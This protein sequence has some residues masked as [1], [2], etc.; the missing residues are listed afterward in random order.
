MKFLSF[1]RKFSA[2][3]A[4]AAGL[5]ICSGCDERNTVPDRLTV[6]RGADQCSADGRFPDEVRVEAR[7]GKV[8]VSGVRLVFAAAPGSQ[9]EFSPA[10]GVTDG[11]GAVAVKV[12][13]HGAGDHFFTVCAPEYPGCAPLKLRVLS[14]M[15]LL[16]GVREAVAGGKLRTPVAVR[17]VR[18]G[19]GV[20]GVPVRFSMR[21]TAEGAETTA[22][23]SAPDA[24]TDASGTAST[25]VRLGRETGIYNLAVDVDG[26]AQGFLIRDYPVRLV[27][28]NPWRVG[29]AVLGGVALFIFGMMLMSDG[30]RTAAGERM[31][32]ILRF[33]TGNRVAALL[34]GTVVTA[35]L[36]SSAAVTV[37][38]IGFINAGLLTLQQ[39]LGI[40]FGA[41]IGTT[42]TAQIISFDLSG[43]ALPAVAAGVILSFSKRR[44]AKN[45]GKAVIGFG[46]L[47]YGLNLMSGELKL[48]GESSGFKAFFASFDCAPAHPGGIV[49]PLALLGAMFVGLAGTVILQSSSAFTGVTL[50]LAAGGLVNFYTAF[51]LLLGSNIGTTVTTLLAAAR[52]N[53]V[54][55]QAALAHFIFN[56]A[57]AVLMAAL[58][59]VPY[60]GRPV[61][62]GFIN[63]ITP[64]DAFAAIPQNLERH[65][66]MAHTFF[67]VA[68]AALLLPFA[69]QFA[70]L[71]GSILPV[72]DAAGGRIRILE[73]RLLSTPS[74]ALKQASAALRS[75][76][77]EA[78]VM[79]DRAV[80]R[81]FLPGDRGDDGAEIAEMEERVDAA[82]QEITDYLVQLSRRPLT[83]AQAELI[84]LLM[85]ATNDAERIADHA[86]NIIELTIRMQEGGD[87]LSERAVASLK[88]LWTTLDD[89]AR[90]VMN[91]LGSG[92]AD[93]TATALADEQRI[94]RETARLETE[95][96]ERLRKGEC[97]APAGVI[98]IE[99]L[100]ELEKI[101]D[102]LANIAERTPRIRRHR[103][104]L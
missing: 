75:M 46:L 29:A 24:I 102:R 59:Y 19:R 74:V 21:A 87:K 103:A 81:H 34:A 100:G 73:P 83:R 30:L 16:P 1:F 71:C 72:R 82:Q 8:P 9:I 2:I 96:I 80:N 32:S 66:A 11:G 60:H 98:Y 99:M 64:G 33:F 4:L 69:A 49:P 76:V 84:P 3:A 20:P 61:F 54:A 62:L 5:V 89:E 92:N 15:E 48:L 28:V 95:H 47:F 104:N 58:F 88:E 18:N 37:M 51:A 78:W 79:I 10:S 36:Q 93:P 68:V 45:L 43:A 97:S 101:G 17:L 57:G 13:A 55:G 53:R 23:I 90:Q 94:N 67:N 14:G 25:E 12:V 42:V 44:V 91:G 22:A 6:V 7:R 38:V 39:S 41:N 26:A 65:I 63:A 56:V 77:E 52:A 85:H 31:K 70:R 40:I 50:A 86:E 35:G 27:A